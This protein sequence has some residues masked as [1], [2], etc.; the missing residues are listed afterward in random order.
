MSHKAEGNMVLVI[1]SLAA[2]GARSGLAYF[3]HFL[4]GS[5]LTG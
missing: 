3:G 1:M 4:R 2:V 5:H